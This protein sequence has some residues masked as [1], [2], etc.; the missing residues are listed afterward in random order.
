MV[1]NSPAVVESEG[2]FNQEWAEMLV[3]K[4]VFEGDSS[5]W[6]ITSQNYKQVLKAV[7]VKVEQFEMSLTRSIGSSPED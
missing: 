1:E 5:T 7:N 6:R 4:A 3:D 2:I